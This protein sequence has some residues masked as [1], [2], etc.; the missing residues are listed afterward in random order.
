MSPRRYVEYEGA[1]LGD[2][3]YE[4]PAHLEDAWELIKYLN[5]RI[6]KLEV[7]YE[8][9]KTMNALANEIKEELLEL[10]SDI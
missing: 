1:V 5:E 7:R 2:K 9:E 6:E 3:W 4:E 8:E 10:K